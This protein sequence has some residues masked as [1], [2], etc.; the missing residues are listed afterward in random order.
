MNVSRSSTMKPYAVEAQ[1]VIA[2][3]ALPE[4]L[5]RKLQVDLQDA[6]RRG[7]HVDVEELRL[8]LARGSEA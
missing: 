1:Q 6:V 3:G 5:K 7:F 2:A 8:A 4:T